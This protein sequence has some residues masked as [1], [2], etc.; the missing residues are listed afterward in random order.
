MQICRRG[1]RQQKAAPKNQF[2]FLLKFCLEKIGSK[3]NDLQQ[4][5]K[6]MEKMQG[7]GLTI[8]RT[9]SSTCT[10]QFMLLFNL[11]FCGP[12]PKTVKVLTRILKI[13]HTMP[14]LYNKSLPYR[15]K[16]SPMGMAGRYAV[17][18][19]MS[20]IMIFCFGFCYSFSLERCFVIFNQ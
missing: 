7:N 1:E 15:I 13:V 9:I 3:L 16:V 14:F 2:S 4:G 18:L 19:D 12:R 5:K 10:C 20:R 6:R 17:N 11:R 8:G